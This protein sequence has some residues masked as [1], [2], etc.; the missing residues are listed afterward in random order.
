MN[1]LRFA[2]TRAAQ[3]RRRAARFGGTSWEGRAAPVVRG[4]FPA[5]PDGL[6]K[7]Q[8]IWLRHPGRGNRSASVWRRTEA[9]RDRKTRTSAGLGLPG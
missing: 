5:T 3:A 6:G 2:R 9:P 1:N 4:C 8:D 7:R